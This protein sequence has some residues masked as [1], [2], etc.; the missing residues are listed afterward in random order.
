MIDKLRS[1][2]MHVV[3]EPLPLMGAPD[4]PSEDEYQAFVL[5][6]SESARGRALLA[7]HARR[8]RAAESE[9]LLSSVQRLEGL[10]RSYTEAPPP[11]PRDE[12]RDMIEEIR[13]VQAELDISQLA[14]QVARLAQLIEGVQQRIECL[15]LPD[16]DAEA[17]APASGIETMPGGDI[18]FAAAAEGAADAADAGPEMIA[19]AAQAVE[20]GGTDAAMQMPAAEAEDTDAAPEAE[21]PDLAQADEAAASAETA[22]PPAETP[23]TGLAISALVETLAVPAAEEHADTE[24]KVYKAGTIPPPAPFAGEDFSAGKRTRA[25]PPPVDPLADIEA[26]TEDERLALFT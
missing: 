16:T 7:E 25:V 20:A 3:D 18:D 5:A 4:A 1:Q 13:G 10:V 2:G 17:A 8:S 11:G 24:V 14:E 26:L 6:L 9:V 19:D 15:S 22:P 23:A 21:M 12:F